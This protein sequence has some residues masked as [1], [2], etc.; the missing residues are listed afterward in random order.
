MEQRIKNGELQSCTQFGP[1]DSDIY[2][3]F[4]KLY[5]G[6]K[7]GVYAL[8]IVAID[9]Q[10]NRYDSDETVFAV[11]TKPPTVRRLWLLNCVVLP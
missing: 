11:D 3:N 1:Y 4:R 2:E 9:S 10:G 6:L 7:E 5:T 8:E